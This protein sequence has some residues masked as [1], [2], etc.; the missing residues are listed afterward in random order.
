MSVAQP[1]PSTRVRALPWLLAWSALWLLLFWQDL[2]SAAEVWLSSNTYTHCIFILPLAAYMAW[3]GRY[4]LHGREPRPVAWLAPAILGWLLVWGVGYAADLQFLSH[5]AMLSVVPMSVMIAL[6]FRVF[7]ALWFPLTFMM[8]ALPFGEEFVPY[9]QVLTADNA[10]WLLQAAGVPVYREGLYLTIPAGQF[11]V[12]E[13]CSGVRFLIASVCFGYFYAF[14]TYIDLWRRA[15]FFAVAI[16]LP[17]VA[18]SL[19]VFMI[20]II[21][22]ETDMEYAVGADH[23]VYGW[24]FFTFVLV[25]LILI[26]SLWRQP[27]QEERPADATTGLL[28]WGQASLKPMVILAFAPL[29]LALAWK[30]AIQAAP[31]KG[32]ASGSTFDPMLSL[33]GLPLKPVQPVQWQPQ[34]EGADATTLYQLGDRA[35]LFVARFNGLDENAELVSSQHRLHREERWTPVTGAN[36]SGQAPA[37]GR[38]QLAGAYGDR[39]HLLYWYQ[40][41][42]YR[43]YKP[44]NVKLMQ[45][46]NR[47]TLEEGAPEYFVAIAFEPAADL[48]AQWRRITQIAEQIS[49]ELSRDAR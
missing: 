39:L 21:A 5:L 1:M 38:L 35:Q 25:C 31:A 40:L 34:F 48:E 26:G 10:V 2:L 11:V 22:H 42:D 36:A 18:N 15:L 16:V 37:L 33:T 30:M 32:Q 45:A 29:L 28:V 23:L 13:A 8:F 46:L 47:L 27:W 41:P 24:V 4:R 14:I 7:H 3:R 17:L 19:R 44:V 9:L 43:H 12:A 20:I 6:G 49:Q